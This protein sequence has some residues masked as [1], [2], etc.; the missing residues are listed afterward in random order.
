M[1]CTTTKSRIQETFNEVTELSNKKN[2]KAA[3]ELAINK[4][5]DSICKVRDIL[6]ERA[7][8]ISEL[9]LKMAK[10]SHLENLDDE[11][12]EMIRK[13]LDQSKAFHH[14]AIRNYVELNWLIRK[15]IA[16]EAMHAY[17][18]ALNDLKEYTE[19]LEDLFFNLPDDKEFA[20]RIEMLSR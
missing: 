4:L 18:D 11:C 3:H 5:L 17:K 10:L 9:N 6:F 2:I 15:G 16:T 12:F 20:N 7:S 13:I 1:E 19:D 14:K 8:L